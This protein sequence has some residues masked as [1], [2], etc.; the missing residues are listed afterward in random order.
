MVYIQVI[1]VPKIYAAATAGQEPGACLYV[2]KILTR[3]CPIHDQYFLP[4]Q[5]IHVHKV[6]VAATVGWD[7]QVNELGNE[8]L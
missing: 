5:A 6:S 1:V 2:R 7:N 8:S 3:I 4:T